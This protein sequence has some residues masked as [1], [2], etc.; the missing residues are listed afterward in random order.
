[1]RYV[2]E[3]NLAFIHVPKNAGQSIANALARSAPL[4][5]APMAAD[6]GVTEAEMEATMEIAV[7]V[8]GLGVVQ[9]DHIP[10]VFIQERLPR[11]WS[12]LA[13]ANSFILTR[14]P[15]DRF[16]SALMQRLREHGGTVAIRV[17][18]P[19][20]SEEAQRV[21][22][23]LEG[24]GPFFERE[25]IH[26]TRQIDYAEV[27]GDRIVTA[28]F[29]VQAADAVAAWI[30][31]EAGL[32]LDVTHDHRRREP[33]SWARAIQP[34]AR[35]VA[36][37]LIPRAIK[38]A[39]YPLWMNSGAFADAAQRYDAVHLGDDVER[40]IAD[41]YAPDAALHAEA[42]AFASRIPRPAEQAVPA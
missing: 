19:R 28:I 40:F 38:K 23:W 24:R 27:S 1:L 36:R 18:D 42:L 5:Y 21:C 34:A 10:L 16:L 39:I 11:T 20:V 15:R 9:P 33:K 41:Y 35:F 8:P 3:K 14:S 30:Q 13:A 22:E 7:E 12:A 17:D 25:F 6:F 31:R 4:S 32:A 37:R 29:P 2:E 26:F